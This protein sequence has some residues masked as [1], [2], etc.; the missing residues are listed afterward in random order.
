M[1]DNVTTDPVF[2][3][4]LFDCSGSMER[5]TNAVISGHGVLLNAL[6]KSKKC[7]EGG[8]FVYQ[9][10]F[11]DKTTN[12]N[13]SIQMYTSGNDAIMKLD[14]NN[15]KPLGNTAIYD[16]LVQMLEDIERVIQHSRSKGL[17]A[18]CTIAI[19]TDGENNTGKYAADDAKRRVEKLRQRECIL[20]SVVLGLMSRDLTHEKLEEIRQSIGFSEAIG[21]DRNEREIRRAFVLASDPIVSMR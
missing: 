19:I 18:K 10:L 5:F 17:E 11:N 20:S 3:Y 4:F 15:Y 12:L 2:A 9:S 6:R 7:F 14:S 16:A 13:P 8:L 21:L 1:L